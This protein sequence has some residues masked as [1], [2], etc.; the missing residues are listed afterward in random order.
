LRKMEKDGERWRKMKKIDKERE[1]KE[2]R[3]RE[4]E[5]SIGNANE[6]CNLVIP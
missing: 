5:R 1:K 4:R 3:E 2:L 6:S